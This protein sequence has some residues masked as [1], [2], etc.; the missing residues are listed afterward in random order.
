MMLLAR[1]VLSWFVNPY[2]GNQRGPVHRINNLLVQLTE[3]IVAPCRKL[4]SRFN[5]GMF[6]FSVL[7]AMLA[8]MLVRNLLFMFL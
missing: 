4:L 2:R 6:D 8:V 7:V 1:A 5:T 3:P